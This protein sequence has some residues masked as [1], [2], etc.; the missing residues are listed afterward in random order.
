MA[1]WNRKSND[2]GM[3]LSR[4]GIWSMQPWSGLDRRKI[5]MIKRLFRKSPPGP[6][7]KFVGFTIWRSILVNSEVCHSSSAA[8]EVGACE[9]VSYSRDDARRVLLGR[10]LSPE[11]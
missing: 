9:T 11:P 2:V 6:P 7:P 4:I 5:C 3:P 8:A 10:L 1:L